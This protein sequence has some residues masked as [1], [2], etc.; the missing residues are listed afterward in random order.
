M[1]RISIILVIIWMIV[2]FTFSNANG[3]IST[4]QSEGLVVKLANLIN[5]TGDINNIRF[6]VRKCAH[7]TEYFILGLLVINACKYNGVKNMIILSILICL[8]Y[9]CT[10]ELHQ[11]F[12]AG[13]EGKVFDVLVDG[14]GSILGIYLYKVVRKC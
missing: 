3:V 4:S 14:V 7:M 13:R 1:K 5:Y 9:A 11:L 12:I 6:V 10:D 8:A 2:I